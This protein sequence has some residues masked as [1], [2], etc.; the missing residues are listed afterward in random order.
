MVM[1]LSLLWGF[2]MN[3][4]RVELGIASLKR[5]HQPL[6]HIGIDAIGFIGRAWT[7]GRVL[8]VY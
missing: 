2:R 5:C 8:V 4:G 6:D 3:V 7:R 1:L